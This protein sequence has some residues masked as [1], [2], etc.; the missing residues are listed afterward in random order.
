MTAALLRRPRFGGASP[1]PDRVEARRTRGIGALVV[2]T[3]AVL[4]LVAPGAANAQ[5]ADAQGWWTEFHQSSLPS[6]PAPPDVAADEL[7]LQGGDPARLL[8]AGILDQTP[9]PTALGA[10]RFTVTPGSE[11]GALVLTVAA[12]AQAAD[13]R[14]YPAKG[15]WVPA[16]GGAIQDAPAPDLSRYSTGRLLADGTT[17]VFPDIGRLVTDQGVLSVVLVPGPADRVVVHAPRATALAVTAPAEPSPPDVPATAPAQ[18]PA[19]TPVVPAVPVAG[20]LPPVQPLPSA[21]ATPVI[22]VPPAPAAP[23]TNPAAI[24]RRVVPDDTRTLIIVLVEALLVIAYFGLLGQGP[25]AVL[26]RLTG[27]PVEVDGERGVG[28]FRAVR[29]GHAPRL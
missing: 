16:Q 17:L 24:S 9:S 3:F 8:P 22:G 12:G 5:G 13:V 1:D 27:Q 14:A 20:P 15:S 7:L 21:A 2:A 23:V 25:L 18:S 4:A 11:V 19:P 26:A 28:R 6:P 10:L 29:T